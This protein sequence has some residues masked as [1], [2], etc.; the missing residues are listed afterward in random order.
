MILYALSVLV[1]FIFVAA[2]IGCILFM[3]VLID[4]LTIWWGERR[5]R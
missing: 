4:A 2:L 3:C 5:A 1:F